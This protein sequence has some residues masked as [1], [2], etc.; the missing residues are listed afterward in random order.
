MSKEALNKFKLNL[1]NSFTKEKSKDIV[2]DF[3][4]KI[5]ETGFNGLKSISFV[6]STDNNYAFKLSYDPSGWGSKQ[7]FLDY[8]DPIVDNEHLFFKNNLIMPLDHD[9]KQTIRIPTRLPSFRTNQVNNY[10]AENFSNANL[11]EDL[12]PNLYLES[13]KNPDL[14]IYKQNFKTREDFLNYNEATEKTSPPPI[15]ILDNVLQNNTLEKNKTIFP[16]YFEIS[17][18]R[19]N[20]KVIKE[21]LKEAGLFTKFLGTTPLISEKIIFENNR[22]GDVKTFSFKYAKMNDLIN[23]LDSA[24]TLGA[25][26]ANGGNETSVGFLEKM[27]LMGDLSKKSLLNSN[28]KTIVNK[29]GV[30]NEFLFYKIEK[31]SGDAIGAP[32][33]TYYLPIN[34]D[35]TKLIDTQIKSGAEYTYQVSAYVAIYG[36]KYQYELI[37]KTAGANRYEANYRIKSNSEIIVCQIPVFI[38]KFRMTERAPLSPQVKFFSK[39]NNNNHLKIYLDKRTGMEKQRFEFILNNDNYSFV[40][41]EDNLE[42]QTIFESGEAPVNFE[43]FRLGEKPKSYKEFITGYKGDTINKNKKN[44][45]AIVFVDKISFNKKYYYTF[46][47]KTSSGMKS[48]PTPI[49]EVEL[50]K[51]SQQTKVNVEICQIPDKEQFVLSKGF[52]SL[53]QL[54]PSIN[55]TILNEKQILPGDATVDDVLKAFYLGEADVPIWDRKFKI[56]IKSN[57]SGKIIDFNVK[58]DLV[59]EKKVEDL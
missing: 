33:Q 21:S 46:R 15:L 26:M 55:H 27:F 5:P 12:I 58:F 31:F 22:S 42:G 1:Q 4:K 52:R 3:W 49:Y 16:S 50:I 48:N 19:T 39:S 2:L 47:S 43:I 25:S 44:S 11:S 34:S 24:P 17:L 7:N 32:V 38:H 51:D 57:D 29:D 37:S 36:L 45:D 9:V 10:Y 14:N 8:E 54:R 13:S 41:S 53:L 30:K 35:V 56:R 40:R 6:P 28:Y 23:N 18:S 59:K 20:D